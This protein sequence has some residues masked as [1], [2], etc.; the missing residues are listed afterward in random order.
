MNTTILSYNISQSR[1]LWNSVVSYISKKK[2]TIVLLQE[3]PKKKAVGQ[4]TKSGFKSF[5]KKAH[6]GDLVILISD[7]IMKINSKINVLS[8][9][10][11]HQRIQLNG[12]DIVNVHMN[13]R[14]QQS[15]RRD[16]YR[17]NIRTIKANIG[18]K[19]IIGGDFNENPFD[20][21][22]TITTGWFAKRTIAE[23]A[24][25]KENGF[26][27][28]FWHLIRKKINDIPTGTIK[29]D[30]NEPMEMAIFDQFILKEELCNKIKSYGLLNKLGKTSID[31]LNRTANAQPKNMRGKKD[32][33]WPIY[34][35]IE[36]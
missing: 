9:N 13:A 3:C 10:E 2:N 32:R 19:A 26:I 18:S 24:K 4:L 35:T 5:V 25:D 21:L 33:H 30:E 29:A 1:F 28:P 6:A 31:S 8:A 12:V 23:I 15:I 20:E 34:I 17:D 22:M 14:K 16:K 11:N 7:D 36:L 27:N